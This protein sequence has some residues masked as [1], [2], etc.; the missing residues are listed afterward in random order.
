M[1]LVL[2]K[3]ISEDLGEEIKNSK[4]ILGK[5]QVNDV[6]VISTETSKYVIR[7]D[8]SESNPIRFEKKLGV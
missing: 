2:Q 3:I 7:I 6:F 5:G 1:N 8:P 4:Q